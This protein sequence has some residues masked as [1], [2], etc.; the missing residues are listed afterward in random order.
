MV[1]S[2]P[3]EFLLSPICRG[4]ARTVLVERKITPALVGV[5][6][7][8]CYYFYMNERGG[9][10]SPDQVLLESLNLISGRKAKF[11][12]REILT[13]ARSSVPVGTV[14]EGILSEDVKIGRP[15]HFSSNGPTI[16]NISEVARMGEKIF[17]RTNTSIYELVVSQT[18]SLQTITYIDLQ[19]E[20]TIFQGKS[21]GEWDMFNN[22]V[23]LKDNPY[24]LV[25]VNNGF[26]VGDKVIFFAEK[27]RGGILELDSSGKLILKGLDGNSWG[28]G[29]ILLDKTGY[30]R[31]P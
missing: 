10:K 30:I 9:I 25:L 12:K 18:E 7:S 4:S 16:S 8:L 31:K 11:I 2:Q 27:E 1:F 29:G 26:K 5:F 15:I 23:P 19:R 14:Y 28:I 20:L 22:R 21:Y 24:Q 17:F 6:T 13:G 3:F